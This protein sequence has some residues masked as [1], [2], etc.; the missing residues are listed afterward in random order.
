MLSEL[1]W[2]RECYRRDK[3]LTYTKILTNN[4]ACTNGLYYLVGKFTNQLECTQWKREREVQSEQDHFLS[5]M[6]CWRFVSLLLLLSLSLFLSRSWSH[7][8]YNEIHRLNRVHSALQGGARKAVNTIDKQVNN[9]IQSEPN[10]SVARWI[11]MKLP[12]LLLNCI[13]IC[14]WFFR[15][16]RWN[17]ER[18]RK[19]SFF[20]CT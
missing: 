8:F 3:D 2:S 1:F 13:S 11:A 15:R 19:K 10:D 4:W 17:I 9:S 5:D 6:N 14:W 16:I 12:P 7:E 18:R 20:I